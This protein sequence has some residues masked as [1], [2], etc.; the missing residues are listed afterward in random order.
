MKKLITITVNFGTN[1]VQ[2]ATAKRFKRIFNRTY[3]RAQ[4]AV[5]IPD[6]FNVDTFYLRKSNQIYAAS[7]HQHT[8][9]ER[10]RDYCAMAAGIIPKI[11]NG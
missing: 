1:H 11:M 3:S 9:R 6:Y 4:R 2:N 5:Y 8:A 10:E 7:I